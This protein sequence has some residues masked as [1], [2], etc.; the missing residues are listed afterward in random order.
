VVSYL[1]TILFHEQADRYE[2]V[3][4][5]K[6]QV[7]MTRDHLWVDSDWGILAHDHGSPHLGR[8]ISNALITSSGYKAFRPTLNA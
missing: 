4:A 8:V 2:A 5:A 3:S 1:D 7:D 6:Q